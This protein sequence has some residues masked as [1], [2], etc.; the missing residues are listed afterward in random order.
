[1]Q[2]LP[3]SAPQIPQAQLEGCQLLTDRIEMLRRLPQGGMVA[4]MGATG[5]DNGIFAL[6]NPVS[7]IVGI[8]F[9]SRGTA[10]V[11]IAQVSIDPAPRTDVLT[12]VG[13]IGSDVAQL[14]RNGTLL[15]SDTTTNQGTGN[16]LAYPLY[17]GRRGGTTLPFNGRIYQ[18]IVRFGANLNSIQ[19]SNTERYINNRKTGAY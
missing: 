19:I 4:E 6:A 8:W 15:L 11:T 9:R 14:R 18:L 17:I 5:G 12:G 13:D 7:S 1:V 10:V 3:P 2:P 16:Y